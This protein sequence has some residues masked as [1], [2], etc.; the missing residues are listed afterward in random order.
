M[1]VLWIG[2]PGD[3][4]SAMAEWVPPIT[5]ITVDLATASGAL[6]SGAVRPDML[7]IDTTLDGL[8]VSRLLNRLEADRIDLPLVLLT[9]PR[10]PDQAAPS[11]SLT[12]FECVVKTEDFVPQLRSALEQARTRHDLLLQLR[13]SRRGQDRLRAILEYQPAVTCAF[14]PDGI[15]TAMNQAGLTLL[16]ATRDQV[17]GQPVSSF[18]AADD[19][20]AAADLVRRVH[21]AEPAE[22]TM[23]LVRPDGQTLRVHLRAVPNFYEGR[24]VALASLEKRDAVAQTGEPAGELA[25]HDLADGITQPPVTAER[26]AL[27][28]A[29][30]EATAEIEQLRADH[31]ASL[32]TCVRLEAELRDASELATALGRTRADLEAL[33]TEKQ[34]GEETHAVVDAELRHRNE[35]LTADLRRVEAALE[36]VRGEHD[37]FISAPQADQWDAFRPPMETAGWLEGLPEARDR[38]PAPAETINELESQ[39][40]EHVERTEALNARLLDER[41]QL[42]GVVHILTGRCQEAD[43]DIRKLRLA[44]RDA[45]ARHQADASTL[46]RLQVERDSLQIRS[47]QLH[48][49]LEQVTATLA[50]DRLRL[51]EELAAARTANDMLTPRLAAEE[52]RANDLES[53]LAS[54]RGLL[55]EWA[56]L[57][58]PLAANHEAALALRE[59]AV[60]AL[61]D[62]LD[63]SA[64]L[65]RRLEDTL[66][67]CAELRSRLS[68]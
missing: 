56:T 68:S 18:F 31:A 52:A 21:R 40:R 13:A 5:V 15:L 9:S 50:G 43:A 28:V 1:D 10:G 45:E 58:Q 22:A 47:E 55:V 4:R 61:S 33:H 66:R 63:R 53:R 6:W 59:S 24:L 36:Q 57:R 49:E 42:T 54:A 51:N 46:A 19:Q 7:V 34:R 60:G 27:T 39:I 14:G 12:T 65:S 2:E 37:R 23:T 16:G 48:I 20:P 41:D 29:L 17:V 26:D 44:A 11:V 38:E 3:A 30:R 8:D 62:A 67:R 64:Q 35:E 32:A 25:A